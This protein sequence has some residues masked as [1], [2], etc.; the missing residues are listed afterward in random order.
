MMLDTNVGARLATLSA[1]T[2][3][4]VRFWI[5]SIDASYFEPDVIVRRLDGSQVSLKVALEAVVEGLWPTM[6]GWRTPR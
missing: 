6:L 1:A 5:G 3:G 4:D 2:A